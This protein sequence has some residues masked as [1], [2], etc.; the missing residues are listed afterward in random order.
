MFLFF[1]HLEPNIVLILFLFFR[2]IFLLEYPFYSIESKICNESMKILYT[3]LYSS[4]CFL[5][6][7]IFSVVHHEKMT[8]LGH[9]PASALFRS[10][11]LRIRVSMFLYSRF[12]QKSVL[13]YYFNL[14]CVKG[15]SQ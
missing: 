10:Y 14:L 8:V 13:V 7:N 2:D 1:L 5:V 3:G 9:I 15:C 11:F 6:F 4:E 12:L